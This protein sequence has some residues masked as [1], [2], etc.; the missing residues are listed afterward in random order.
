V[1]GKIRSE[2]LR[3]TLLTL[4]VDIDNTEAFEDFFLRFDLDRD[5]LIDYAEFKSAVHSPSNLES[6]CRNVP[7]WQAIANAIPRVENEMSLRTV[8]RLTDAQIDMICRESEKLI[9]HQL[10]EERTQLKDAFKAMDAHKESNPHSKFKT[11]FK[12]SAGTCKDYHS[13][14]KDR[15]GAGRSSF[16]NTTDLC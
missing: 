4:K 2:S 11:I 16:P 6:W 9:K 1:E 12:A 8:A 15:V 14:L 3:D 7:W 5:G 10:R 13:G